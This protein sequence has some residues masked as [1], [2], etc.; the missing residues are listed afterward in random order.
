[1]A[2]RGVPADLATRSLL[3]RALAARRCLWLALALGLASAGFLLW[4]L[5][6]PVGIILGLRLSKLAALVVVGSAAGAATLIFQTVIGNQLLTPNLMG[7]DALYVFLQTGLVFVLGGVGYAAIGPGWSFVM[8]AGVLLV[9]VLGIFRVFLRGGV[10][11]VTRVVLSGVVLGLLL[12]GMTEL[13]G[14]LIDPSEFSIVQQAVVASFGRVDRAELMVAAVALILALGWAWRMAPALDV[15]GLGRP[16]A[17]GLGLDHDRLV[18]RALMLVVVL[19]AVATALV[20]PLMFLG[21]LAS[22]LTRF[23]VPTHRHAL[24][25]PAAAMTGAL[26]L[27]AG[28]FVFERLMGQQSALEV[29][30]EFFGGLVFLALVLRRRRA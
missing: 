20:G 10:R 12:R 21:L 9:V 28:Q 26:I 19:V 16:V 23:L 22:S 25:I 2:E 14:R 7:L 27:V 3:P 18:Q 24:L 13:M 15:A 30:V 17:R 11:D 6:G 4:Q 1:M 8:N 29:V 5:Q